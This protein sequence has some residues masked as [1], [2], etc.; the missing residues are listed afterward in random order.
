MHPALRFQRKSIPSSAERYAWAVLYMD[1][2]RSTRT[3]AQITPRQMENAMRPEGTPHRIKGAVLAGHA[4]E[5]ILMSEITSL[6]VEP[7]QLA[8]R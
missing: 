6:H 3:A 2:T 5:A 8:K 7:R 1:G 4:L